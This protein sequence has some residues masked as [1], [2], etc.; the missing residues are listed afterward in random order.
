[1]RIILLLIILCGVVFFGYPLLNEGVGS[2]CDA[3]ER[4]T[5]R[6][7]ADKDDKAARKQEL[8]IGQLFQG[9]SQ[10]QLASIWVKDEH[11]N[12]PPVAAC[13]YLY[14][15]GIVDPDAIKKEAKKFGS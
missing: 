9:L 10:G 6:T 1:M 5:V 2:E 7:V 11:P 12:L 8:A 13:T 4:S 14:W 3:F 15:K